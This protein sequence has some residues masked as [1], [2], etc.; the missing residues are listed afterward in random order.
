ME[1][2]Q[3]NHLDLEQ[4]AEIKKI[5]EQIMYEKRNKLSPR[6]KLEIEK[7]VK[8]LLEGASPKEAIGL[9]KER[10]EYIYGQGYQFFKS[11]K[12]KEA[13]SI[14]TYLYGFD[15]SSYRYLF[16]IASSQQ[17][18]GNY[19]AA[20]GNYM[21]CSALDPANPAP[22]FHCYEC[23]KKVN[24]PWAALLMIINCIEICKLDKDYAKLQARAELEMKD[25]KN[26][27]EKYIQENK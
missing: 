2:T 23:F 3:L 9:T 15:R 13:L 16:S 12:Y 27:L 11:G 14:F 1:N 7:A 8:K 10:E 24:N 20:G 25:I 4:K 21:L 22:L 26:I 6:D 18:M 19:D 5:A 17:L